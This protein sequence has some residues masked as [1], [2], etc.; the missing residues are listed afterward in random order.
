[1]SAPVQSECDVDVDAPDT[2]HTLPVFDFETARERSF[3]RRFCRHVLAGDEKFRTYYFHNK[4]FMSRIVDDNESGELK[5]NIAMK[6]VR[7]GNLRAF[8]LLNPFLDHYEMGLRDAHGRNLLHIACNLKVGTGQVHNEVD[9]TEILKR[10][11]S[12]CLLK[13]INLEDINGHSPLQ[14]CLFDDSH[15]CYKMLLDRNA[16]PLSYAKQRPID[17]VKVAFDMGA[18]GCAE[19]LS[20]RFR[21]YDTGIP[22]TDFD[23]LMNHYRHETNNPRIADII[24]DIKALTPFFNETNQ[25]QRNPVAEPETVQKMNDDDDD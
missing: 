2:T 14:L 15:L 9:K 25:Q 22:A 19:L 17:A 23:W 21:D 8:R 12:L 24:A 18:L 20:E 5:E 11:L 1:M 4:E 16:E 13:D 6:V 3:F 10:V 7:T